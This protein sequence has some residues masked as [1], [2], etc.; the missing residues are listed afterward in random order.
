MHFT[1]AV[2]MNTL[3]HGIFHV[4][5]RKAIGFHRWAKLLEQNFFIGKTI[6]LVVKP[7]GQNRPYNYL[8]G[9]RPQIHETPDFSCLTDIIAPKWVFKPQVNQK[10]LAYM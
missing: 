9:A 8:L 1:Q 4:F 3:K 7:G 6:C 2:A 5:S 10:K